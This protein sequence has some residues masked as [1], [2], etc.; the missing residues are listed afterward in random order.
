MTF[1]VGLIGGGATAELDAGKV[2]IAAT[3]KTNIIAGTAIARGDLRA[4]SPEQI[5]AR[6]GEDAGDRRPDAARR[7]GARSSST[8]R[9]SADGADAGNRRC[10]TG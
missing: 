2:R 7:Q 1:N 10:S 9:L 4:I 8:R 6:Q 3:G 5:A